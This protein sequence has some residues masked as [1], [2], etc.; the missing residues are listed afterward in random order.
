MHLTIRRLLNYA[1]PYRVY[2][3]LTVL[4]SVIGVSLSLLVPVYIGKAIDLAVPGYIV[5]SVGK[6]TDLPM[7]EILIV[8]VQLCIVVGISALFQWLQGLC[9]NRL[10]FGT[11]KDL[12]SDLEDRLQHLP[13][14]YIDGNARGDLIA[15]VVPDIEIVSDGLLQGFAQLFSGIVTIIG[16]LTF[17]LTINTKIALLVVVLTPLSLI[18]AA[19]I[20]NASHNAFVWQSELRGE[21]GGLTEE[22]VGGMNV[23]KAFAY[24]DRAIERFEEINRK[25]G[26]A[27]QKATFFSSISN[28]STRFVNG[29]IYAA[30]GT[31][32]ALGAVGTVPWIG[33]MTVGG[34]AS[35]LAY[36]NQYTKPFNE[37]SGVLA[38]LQNALSCAERVFEVLDAM[39]EQAEDCAPSGDV[40]GEIAFEN[41]NF[42]YS[43]EKPLI[44]DFSMTAKPGQRIAIVG[45]TGCGKTTIINLLLRFYEIGSG[46]ITIDGVST[47]D[48]TR[49][50][51]RRHFGMVLQETWIFTGTVAENIA[52]G[53]PDATRGEIERAAREAH[54]HSFI[55]R[56]PNGYDTVISDASGLSQGQK[57]LLCIARIMLTD[58]PMLILD[59][60]TSSIDL[61]TEQRIQRAF[62]KL[63]EGKTSFIIAHRLSTIRSA[64]LILV[65]KDGNIIEQGTHDQLLRRGG[66]YADLYQSQ[67]T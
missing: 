65:M 33:S 50:D 62:A 31:F 52:Y 3:F 1:K 54:A 42:S 34:L 18:V 20:T 46:R 16:T 45:P 19:R 35:F 47:R 7:L 67:A 24:E 59:E 29:L 66:F 57:Q 27:G 2:L 15:R 41:V 12:R 40:R 49:D 13:I 44:R 32:G 39:P 60:A 23:V 51:L 22:L 4:T 56:L 9:I 14:S 25:L 21:L 17:M 64:D 28:P 36:S 61:R 11:V 8:V 63:M 48:M 5:N 55:K 58:P 38:E 37:I 53:K 26:S 30:V 10:A 43:K 6:P